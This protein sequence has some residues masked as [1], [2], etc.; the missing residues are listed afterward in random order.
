[1]Q[2]ISALNAGPGQLSSQG[3]DKSAVF[4]VPFGGAGGTLKDSPDK[5]ISQHPNYATMRA[6][7]KLQESDVS[8]QPD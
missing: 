3:A 2:P 1:M 5:Y 8:F 4:V 6:I 7:C